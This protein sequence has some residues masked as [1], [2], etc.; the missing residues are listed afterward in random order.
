MNIFDNTKFGAGDIHLMMDSRRK[1]R[2]CVIINDTGDAC[3][4]APISF[5]VKERT[6]PYYINISVSDKSAYID[7]TKLTIINKK[8]LAAKQAALTDKETAY[9]LNRIKDSFK[10]NFNS[11]DL[12]EYANMKSEYND[13]SLELLLSKG[14]MAQLSQEFDIFLSYSSFDKT[15]IAGIVTLLENLGYSVYV[16]FRGDPQ[17]DPNRVNRETAEI[18]R[19]RLHNSRTLLFVLSMNARRSAWMPW[20]L[21]YFDGLKK[22]ILIFPIERMP[23]LK[24][25]YK[26][27]EYL[28]LYDYID[29][30]SL[31]TE[32]VSLTVHSH[33]RQS[34]SFRE[35]FQLSS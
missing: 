23:V 26:G 18:I 31:G 16:D 10:S 9:I 8:R 1:D 7:L 6:K 11:L 27:Q 35:W 21:G 22:R 15:E 28:N 14:T 30:G 19:K 33:E 3:M 32:D 4:V 13:T 12:V 34:I 20:E 25:R 17:L 2:L 29:K 5:Q 24:K